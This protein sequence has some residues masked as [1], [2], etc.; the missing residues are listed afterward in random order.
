MREILSRRDLR[1]LVL[2]EFLVKNKQ[3]WRMLRDISES[4]KIPIRTIHSDISEINMYIRPLYIKAS[5]SGVKIF[6]PPN[7]SERY[8]Y[9]KILEESLE[10]K[11]IEH[12]FM[13]EK[14]TLESLSEKLYI[15][16]STVKRTIKDINKVVE[17]AGFS[18]SGKPLTF[19]GN[20]RK[21]IHFMNFYFKERYMFQNEYMSAEQIELINK[22][23][24]KIL[25]EEK[26]EAYFPNFKRIS[27]WVY[28][29]CVR[30][31]SHRSIPI[32]NPKQTFPIKI[33]DDMD[34]CDKFYNALGVQLSDE[35][36]KQ[37][38]YVYSSENY[39]FNTEE[40]HQMIQKCAAQKSL[41]H[42]IKSSIN[43]LS[44]QLDIPLNRNTEDKLLLDMMNTINFKVTSSSSSY[45]LHD[46][47]GYFL[48]DLSVYYDQ[49]RV[50]I[51]NSLMEN[52]T[53]DI[54]ENE[55]NELTYILL[56]HWSEL[57]HKIRFIELPVK[58]YLLVDT[59]IEHGQL[60]KNELE[61]YSRYHINVENIVNWSPEQMYALED[62]SI[63]ITNIPDIPELSCYT[64][65][66][67]EFLCNRDWHEFSRMT[68]I[69][70][71]KRKTNGK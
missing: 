40:L 56:T 52:I 23:I 38:F 44:D 15:S 12:I 49:L 27:I 58:V 71:A 6:M 18:I 29:V 1:H 11:I 30:L 4:L 26:K 60:I 53:I 63:L 16:D 65:C 9:K 2:L 59:D 66:F 22:L 54:A 3:N 7:Y 64:L 55:W 61:A 41:Y 25:D 37:L 28:L 35:T 34:F 36:I 57:Y 43:T 62:D 31:R 5:S 13:S 19:I 46:R 17:K 42:E 8:I 69:I 33:L 70:L 45:V 14:V 24:T 50:L 51:R 21:L 39:S 47:R 68:D 67:G 48:S 32:V 10:F 20:E